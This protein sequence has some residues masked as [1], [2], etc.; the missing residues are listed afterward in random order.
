MHKWKRWESPLCPFCKLTN[1][2]TIH[3]LQYPY[4][5]CTTAWHQS[6]EPLCKWL[7]DAD[8]STNIT[9]WII[10][11]L[12][13]QPSAFF[14]DCKIS[15]LPSGLCPNADFLTMLLGCLSPW[16]ESFQL[17]YWTSLNI[18]HSP[19]IGLNS[20]VSSSYTLPTHFGHLEPTTSG[21]CRVTGNVFLVFP[22]KALLY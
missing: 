13:V 10:A 2:T 9:C 18:T 20:F 11:T 3:I 21:I 15:G 4:P 12:H 16:W 22:A 19:A 1:E 14:G 6:V 7:C 5:A 8:T 17:H